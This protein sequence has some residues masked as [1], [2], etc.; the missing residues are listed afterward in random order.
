[1]E[2]LISLTGATR[3]QIYSWMGKGIVPRP[4]GKRGKYVSYGP[5]HLRRIRV[6]LDEVYDRRVTLADLTE[7]FNPTDTDDE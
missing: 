6:V 4:I 7:R 3:R 1:M 2:D 5:E